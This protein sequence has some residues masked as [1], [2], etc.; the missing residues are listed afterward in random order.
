VILQGYQCIYADKA[1]FTDITPG[2]SKQELS[3]RSRNSAKSTYGIL[4]RW[5]IKGFL[6]HPLYSIVL[7]SRK[8]ARRFTPFAM[9]SIF[10]SNLFLL[11][12]H[13]LYIISLIL[14]CGFYT[15]GI[16]GWKFGW[17]PIAGQIYSFCL[18]NLGFMLGLFKAVCGR[19]PTSFIPMRHQK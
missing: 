3:A 5:Q 16:I 18:A 10:I 7:I 1:H 15:L 6:L 12:Y 14:Q 11:N 2:L 17:I 9:L 4:T 19:I 8:I 13:T